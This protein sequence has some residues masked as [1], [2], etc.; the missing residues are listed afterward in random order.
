MPQRA[1]F[2]LWF[3]SIRLEWQNYGH[4]LHVSRLIAR[5]AYFSWL[6]LGMEFNGKGSTGPSSQSDTTTGSVI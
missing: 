2:L 3:T 5:V 4:T 6:F 1:W